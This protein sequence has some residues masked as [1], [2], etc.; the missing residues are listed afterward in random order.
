MI[1]DFRRQALKGRHHIKKG[2]SPFEELATNRNSRD[3][4]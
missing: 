4:P 2:Y 3:Q 1:P